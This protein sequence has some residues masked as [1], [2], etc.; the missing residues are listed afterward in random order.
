MSQTG[1]QFLCRF[2][3]T[4]PVGPLREIVCYKIRKPLCSRRRVLK[5][6]KS[7][8]GLFRPR[9]PVSDGGQCI[10]RASQP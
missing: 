4:T 8:F 6:A 5:I 10:S 7:A 2:G 3:Q 9:P 1:G